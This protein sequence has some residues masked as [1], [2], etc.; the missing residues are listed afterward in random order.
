MRSCH[1]CGMPVSSR[2][3]VTA[4]TPPLQTCVRRAGGTVICASGVGDPTS[5]VDAARIEV[6][7]VHACVRYASGAVACWGFNSGGQIGDGTV[8]TTHPTPFLGPGVP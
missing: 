7:G 1:G 5:I 8:G 2:G 6:S 3:L 4:S